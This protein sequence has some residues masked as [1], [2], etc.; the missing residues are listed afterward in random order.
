MFVRKVDGREFEGWRRKLAGVHG[1]P[2][3]LQPGLQRTTGK[4][5]DTEDLHMFKLYCPTDAV[6]TLASTLTLQVVP[7]AHCYASFKAGAPRTSTFDLCF[8]AAVSRA[9]AC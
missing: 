2:A 6:S 7:T 5:N 1:G 4:M 8:K 9:R 3:R